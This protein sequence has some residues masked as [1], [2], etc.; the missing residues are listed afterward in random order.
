LSEVPGG[1][2]GTLTTDSGPFVAIGWRELVDGCDGVN[3]SNLDAFPA[4]DLAEVCKPSGPKA[5]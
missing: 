4:S 5:S 1:A 3:D 2:I